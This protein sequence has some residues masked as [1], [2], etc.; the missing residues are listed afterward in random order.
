ME[1]PWNYGLLHYRTTPVSSTLPSPLEMLT[2]R[3]PH[4]TLP[5]LP[6]TIGKNVGNLQDPS[7]IAQEAT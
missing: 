4:S 3:K 6:S 5:Q 1:K 7:G 2:G